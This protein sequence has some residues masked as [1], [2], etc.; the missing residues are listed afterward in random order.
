MALR[1]RLDLQEDVYMR[2]HDG[3]A[4]QHRCTKLL[5][6][7]PALDLIPRAR[8]QLR[9]DP[10]PSVDFT[11]RANVLFEHGLLLEPWLEPDGF[12]RKVVALNLADRLFRTHDGQ[13]LPVFTPIGSAPAVVST[14]PDLPDP[15]PPSPR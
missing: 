6:G 4:L 12:V 14:I 3:K 8:Y 5:D 13:L 7:A 10:L 11:C 2:T 15:A 9:I 1:V